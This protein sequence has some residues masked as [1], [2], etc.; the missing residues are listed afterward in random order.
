[1]GGYNSK[2]SSGA[3][4]ILDVGPGDGWPLLRLASLFRAVT[5]AEPSQRRVAAITAG[6]EKLGL[7]NVTVKKVSPA[8]LDFPLFALYGEN[9]P[10]YRGFMLLV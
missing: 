7:K 6:V 2:K 4:D 8:G 1:M 5:G 3:Q 10:A 9:F